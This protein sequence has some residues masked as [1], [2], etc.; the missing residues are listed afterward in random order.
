M[1]SWHEE[2]IGRV[3][4]F[5]PSSGGG[6]EA[7]PLRGGVGI[8]DGLMAMVSHAARDQEEG[9]LS[10][11]ELMV[12]TSVAGKHYV[13]EEKYNPEYEPA[14]YFSQKGE[15]FSNYGI[16]ESFEQHVGWE[17]RE[18]NFLSAGDLARLLAFEFQEGRVVL[19]WG[20]SGA[21]E[22]VWLTGMV[23]SPSRFEVT[24]VGGDGEVKTLDLRGEGGS[25]QGESEEDLVNWCVVARPKPR[26]AREVAWALGEDRRRALV[27]GWC[28][29]HGR[30]R[31][32]FFHET[33]ENYATGLAAYETL[34]GSVTARHESM[35]GDE[36]ARERL[37]AQVRWHGRELSEGRG[38][39]ARMLGGLSG[40][41]EAAQRYEEVASLLDAFEPG[42]A[43][44]A[45][46]W[47]QIRQR[48]EEAL[49]QLGA[50]LEALEGDG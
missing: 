43:D 18:F 39:M 29:R 31:K 6:S 13:Y 20:L 9:E 25:L 5:A 48:E 24:Y 44:D 27:L 35:R 38:A 28:V 19:S 49:A 34:A 7:R 21:P 10:R 46:R 3:E 32:E 4:G 12:M 1:S 47:L 8:V 11:D 2:L 37:L 15:L 50:C 22:V 42:G 41:E 23:A 40:F 36:E 33:R 14:R 45:Q 26:A 30:S 17:V 16:F